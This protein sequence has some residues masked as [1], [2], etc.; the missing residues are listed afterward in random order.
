[1]A[2]AARILA[3]T[4]RV[5]GGRNTGI[6]KAATLCTSFTFTHGSR[7]ERAQKGRAF[8]F[9][10]AR[11]TRRSKHERTK[12]SWLRRSWE[13]VRGASNVG[14]ARH[15]STSCGTC[16][17]NGGGAGSAIRSRANRMAG[18]ERSEEHTSELQSLAYL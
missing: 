5:T 6:A 15:G 12:R 18:D 3:T 14:W 16:E 10:C 1:M 8:R 13:H 2:N 9:E 7:R 4:R 17:G 11:R